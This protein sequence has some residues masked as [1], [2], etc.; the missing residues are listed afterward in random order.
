MGSKQKTIFCAKYRSF[1]YK[2][3]MGILCLCM[4]SFFS[5]PRSI[6]AQTSVEGDFVYV[7]GLDGNAC[8]SVTVKS[9]TYAS[10]VRIMQ[11]L[12]LGTILGIAKNCQISLTCANCKV[13]RLTESDSPYTIQISKFK[14]ESPR[15]SEISRYLY[16]ALENF[17]YP[18][19]N[20]GSFI[21]PTVRN[22][23][24]KP[25]SSLHPSGTIIAI[26]NSINFSWTPE[27]PIDSLQI[28]EK[29]THRI[30]YKN[31]KISANGIDLPFKIFKA[32]TEYIWQVRD[33]ETKISYKES[34][35]LLP[36]DAREKIIN[37]LKQLDSILPQE[38]GQENRYRLQA[39]YLKSENLNYDA[40]QCLHNHGVSNP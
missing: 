7:L 22:Y 37:T 39:S 9:D 10:N 1:M 21:Y 20:W 12:Q 11:M 40:W 18:D 30:I 15:F 23:S 38:V 25:I 35:S 19:I 16:V 33:K 32:G 34:F 29:N 26:N 14:Q 27:I 2:S 4:V 24:D 36:K 8:G 31:D 17:I 13:I 5:L 3:L 6:A 28:E